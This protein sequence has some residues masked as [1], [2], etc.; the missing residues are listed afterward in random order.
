MEKKYQF[1][2]TVERL[3]LKLVRVP[4]KSAFIWVRANG[5]GKLLAKLLPTT[6]W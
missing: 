1:V 3:Q 2:L 6:G 4:W 5:W